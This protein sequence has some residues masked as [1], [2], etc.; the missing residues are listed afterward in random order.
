MSGG[1]R[2]RATDAEGPFLL[3]QGDRIEFSVTH[4]IRV[5]GDDSWV[6]Y[7]VSKT[8]SEG[9]TAHAVAKALVDHVNTTVMAAV[10]T[11][12]KA[13]GGST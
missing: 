13:I 2:I 6:K 8:L 11:T 1:L 3:Q 10:H 7:G 9:E 5:D 12:A 4:Q